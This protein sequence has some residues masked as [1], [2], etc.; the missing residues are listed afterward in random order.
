MTDVTPC[1]P[2]LPLTGMPEEQADWDENNRDDDECSRC[3][4]VLMESGRCWYCDSA[5]IWVC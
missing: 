3:Q 4:A 5:W 1:E 2:P